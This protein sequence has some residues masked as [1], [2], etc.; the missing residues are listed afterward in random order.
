LYLYGGHA[1][2]VVMWQS[3]LLSLLII[4]YIQIKHFLLKVYLNYM[5]VLLCFTLMFSDIYD[6]KM[7]YVM[8]IF[9]KV[10]LLYWRKFCIQITDD[11]C[12]LQ[13]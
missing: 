2:V 11:R 10:V 13:N 4:T 6:L 12:I 7:S 8:A 5:Y 9:L 3:W 1:I